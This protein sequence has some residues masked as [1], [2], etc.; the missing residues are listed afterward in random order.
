MAKKIVTWIKASD[1]D[2]LQKF[3]EIEIIVQAKNRTPMKVFMSLISLVENESNYCNY[4]NALFNS[5]HH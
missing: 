3:D 4:E 1:Y 2:K 5:E